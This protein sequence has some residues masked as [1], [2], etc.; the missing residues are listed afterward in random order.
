MRVWVWGYGVQYSI[1]F[2]CVFRCLN[3]GEGREVSKLSE[4]GRTEDGRTD[5]PSV[6]G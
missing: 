5:G 2:V 3:A 1:A 6:G 4:G